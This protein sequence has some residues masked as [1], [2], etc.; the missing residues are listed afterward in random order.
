MLFVLFWL[1]IGTWWWVCG[2]VNHEH[3]GLSRCTYIVFLCYTTSTRGSSTLNHLQGVSTS[4]IYIQILHAW[5]VHVCETGQF[6]FSGCSIP[7]NQSSYAVILVSVWSLLQVDQT[8]N[9]TLEDLWCNDYTCRVD[10][11]TRYV[12]NSGFTAYRS[13]WTASSEGA[14]NYRSS[15]S[16]LMYFSCTLYFSSFFHCHGS[17][18]SFFWQLELTSL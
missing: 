2:D 18:G 6:D 4:G 5:A 1:Y 13:T 16:I 9:N 17:T 11:G 7:A 8:V 12:R 15:K 14:C 3:G 10:L